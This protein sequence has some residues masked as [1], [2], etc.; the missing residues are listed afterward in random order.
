MKMTPL[1]HEYMLIGV[2]GFF[3]SVF[4]INDWS[5]T[6]AFAFGLFFLL[7][8]IASLV[9]MMGSEIDEDSL[10]LIASEHYQN[11]KR[12]TLR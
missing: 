11:Q 10:D 9:S 6:W 8:V 1:P 5:R 2:I 4:L 3:V 12:K 7:L